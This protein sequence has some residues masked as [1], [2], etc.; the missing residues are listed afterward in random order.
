VGT[1]ERDA[2]EVGDKE[3][4][5]VPPVGETL[6]VPARRFAE[7]VAAPVAVMVGENVVVGSAV[8]LGVPVPPAMPPPGCAAVPEAAALVEAVRVGA[9]V[10]VNT[11][12]GVVVVEVE[13]TL[14]VLWLGVYTGEEETEG[15]T[16]PEG[17]MDGEVEVLRE[18]EGVTT[19]VGVSVC[20]GVA[21]SVP[22]EAEMDAEYSG[23]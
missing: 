18:E 22:P 9:R 6:G 17:D 13:G 8:A 23:V 2:R 5:G 21:M 10:A 14:E 16:L 19:A 1:P 3:S 11:C 12:E 7:N 20:V 15:D 4:V